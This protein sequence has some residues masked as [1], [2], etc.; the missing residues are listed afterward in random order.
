MSYFGIYKMGTKVENQSM[1]LK[2]LRGEV[3]CL[4]SGAGVAQD[5][6]QEV[7]QHMDARMTVIEEHMG[8][9]EARLHG[10]ADPAK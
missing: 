9:L 8:R 2:Q 5:Q 4:L 7:Q 6:I 3:E 10:G 1:K